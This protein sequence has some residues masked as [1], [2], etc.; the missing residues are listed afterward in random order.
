MEP[1]TE[2]LRHRIIDDLR[3]FQDATALY[4]VP[5]PIGNTEGHAAVAPID[6]ILRGI[7]HHTDEGVAGAVVL[8][9]TEP[10]VG[11]LIFQDATTM[12]IDMAA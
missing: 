5:T 11:I 3:T 8:V 7:A 6:E 1:H 2:L 10:V 12:G 9:L 4:I